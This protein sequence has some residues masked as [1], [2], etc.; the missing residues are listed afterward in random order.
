[1]D[2]IC[3]LVRHHA[4]RRDWLEGFLPIFSLGGKTG[5]GLGTKLIETPR[6]NYPKTPVVTA[7]VWPFKSGEVAVQAYNVLLSLAHLQDCADALLVLSN[8]SL[9][10]VV[11]QRWALRSTFLVEMNALA[12]RHL[13]CL[14]QP[15]QAKC[16]RSHLQ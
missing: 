13:A 3:N 15:S 14:L 12:A 7:V 1:M 5:S 16:P 2:E 8:D 9:H 6:D 10:R 11:T 4:E